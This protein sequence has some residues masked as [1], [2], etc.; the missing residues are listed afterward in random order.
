MANVQHNS[1]TGAD[2]HYSK[3]QVIAGV[4]SSIPTY[5]GQSVWD[6]IH[7]VLYVANGTSSLANWEPA[8]PMSSTN[9]QVGT[10]YTI[11]VSD[12]NTVIYFTNTGARAITL[13]TAPTNG[14]FVN[15]KDGANNAYT[16]PITISCGG[17]DVFDTGSTSYVIDSESGSITLVYASSLSTWMR[18]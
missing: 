15:L 2:L 3:I 8:L 12:N 14:F 10:T 7:G 18:V 13:I 1:L 16:S 4:P 11:Q 5:V 6:S 17:T 9:V